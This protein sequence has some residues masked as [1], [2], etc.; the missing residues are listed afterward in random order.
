LEHRLLAANEIV[1][2]VFGS[3]MEITLRK[4]FSPGKSRIK[5][6]EKKTSKKKKK[7]E[8]KELPVSRKLRRRNWNMNE[9][10]LPVLEGVEGEKKAS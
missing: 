2:D 10:T 3:G 5:R 1:D 9:T 6:A 4:T 8:E 7:R